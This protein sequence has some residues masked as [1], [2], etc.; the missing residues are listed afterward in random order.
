L[1]RPSEEFVR[2]LPIT[3]DTL[4]KICQRLAHTLLTLVTNLPEG[5]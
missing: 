3:S 4:L 1:L 2:G 5:C